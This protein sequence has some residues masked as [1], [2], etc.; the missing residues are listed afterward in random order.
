MALALVTPA[1]ARDLTAAGC[2]PRPAETIA[3][4]VARSGSELATKTRFAGL[5]T[6]L[7][8]PGAGAA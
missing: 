5:R 7:A 3:A 2:A 6:G 1:A 4:V 8:A